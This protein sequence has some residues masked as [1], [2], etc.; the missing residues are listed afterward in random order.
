M[1]RVL[2]LVAAM[3]ALSLVMGTSSAQDPTSC[4]LALSVHN[5]AQCTAGTLTVDGE[6]DL[7]VSTAIGPLT[8]MFS[9]DVTAVLA[10]ST[11]RLTRSCFYR[12]TNGLGALGE[13]CIDSVE[14]DFTD[15]V[16][17]CSGIASGIGEW[18]VTCAIPSE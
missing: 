15:P 2:L 4:G 16:A 5:N 6:P 10:S 12:A 13:V 18:K 3:T 8:G 1:R 17:T 11:G 14:G 9:G 7:D